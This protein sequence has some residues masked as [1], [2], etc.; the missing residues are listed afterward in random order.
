MTDATN[1][2]P[3]LAPTLLAAAAAT[4]AHAQSPATS[5]LII[6]TDLHTTIETIEGVQAP[7]D[8]GSPGGI[9]LRNN[10]GE[11]VL[12]PAIAVIPLDRTV[13]PQLGVGTHWTGFGGL[14]QDRVLRI[15]QILD[16]GDTGLLTLTD[17]RRAFGRLLIG[18]TS[19][20]DDGLAWSLRGISQT[21]TNDQPPSTRGGVAIIALENVA[22]L[23]LPPEDGWDVPIFDTAAAG[24]VTR[25]DNTAG[26]T[27]VL[28]NGDRVEGFVTT[29]TD[30]VTIELDNGDQQTFRRNILRGVAL[31]N[32]TTQPDGPRLWLDDG[33][34]LAFNT[35]ATQPDANTQQ[36]TID[37]QDF[38]TFTLTGPAITGIIL[39]ASRITP[40]AKL[41][42][43]TPTNPTT[44]S[45]STQ[46]HPDDHTLY[47]SNLGINDIVLDGPTRISFTLPPNAERFAATIALDSPSP[48]WADCI[49]TVLADGQQLASGELRQTQPAFAVNEPVHD[50]QQL[51]IIIEEGA[52]GPVGDRVALRRP[53]VLTADD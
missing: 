15:G 23:I 30:S 2:I 50:A 16:Q 34:V 21:N 44:T 12:Q 52:F 19:A 6:G 49:V 43:T 5:A 51:E 11:L 33:S 1:P 17:G 39:D 32:P 18:G 13:D 3:S 45:H 40:L 47:G 24:S 10:D 29:I 35:I 26:D 53:I 27:V 14:T 7:T 22:R 48:N 36:W 8:E 37:S 28:A 38:G 41:D 25:A 42:A 9:L 46:R 20:S 4:A 31:A